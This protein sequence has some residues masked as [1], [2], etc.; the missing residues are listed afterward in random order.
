MVNSKLKSRIKKLEEK[1]PKG[2]WVYP[3]G[4][5]YSEEGCEPYWTD[6]PVRPYSD[7]YDDI[8]KEEAGER[9]YRKIEK[10]H[11]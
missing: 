3:N 1:T 7:W 5:Y 8:K 11:R 4:Y 6:E 10:P 2:R 9:V